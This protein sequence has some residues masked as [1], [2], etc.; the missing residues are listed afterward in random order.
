MSNK[1]FM[2]VEKM[3]QK[4]HE[5]YNRLMAASLMSYYMRVV[6]FNFDAGIQVNQ[7]LLSAADQTNEINMIQEELDELKLAFDGFYMKKLSIED[8]SGSI[9]G[10]TKVK[11]PFDNVEQQR[12][13]IAD[14]I[15][16]IIYVTM[17]TGAKHGMDIGSVL[18]AIAASNDTKYTDGELVK[19]ANGKIQK[20]PDFMEPDL[21][22]V[23][24]PI[25]FNKAIE[26]FKNGQQA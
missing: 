16:D 5:V 22:F 20:G 24:E 11:T 12:I 19:N 18:Y 1:K 3:K 25:D 13:A 23:A 26:E 15:G 6:G 4:G 17:G 2:D 7:T 9:T 14:A 8:E 21:S 10:T